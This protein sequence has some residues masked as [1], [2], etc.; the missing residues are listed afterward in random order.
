MKIQQLCKPVKLFI[1][2]IILSCCLGFVSFQAWKCLDKFFQYPQGSQLTLKRPSEILLPD[3]SICPGPRFGRRP[4]VEDIIEEIIYLNGTIGDLNV[5]LATTRFRLYPGF[6]AKKIYQAFGSVCFTFSL[7]P[8]ITQ[9]GI[10]RLEMYFI[11]HVFI[12]LHTPGLF[13]QETKYIEVKATTTKVSVTTETPF[14]SPWITKLEGVQ[15]EV[16]DVYEV[17]DEL[18]TKEKPCDTNTEYRRDQCILDEFHKVSKIR[19]SFSVYTYTMPHYFQETMEQFGCTPKFGANECTNKTLTRFTEGLYAD[20]IIDSP[21]NAKCLHPCKKIMPSFS[22]RSN[23]YLEGFSF[24][25]IDFPSEVKVIKAYPAYEVLSLIAEIG[26]Y[27]GLFLGISVMDLK[28]L[29]SFV[30]Q[31][32]K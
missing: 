32:R 8:N 4:E 18:D 5:D 13:F 21:T 25:G 17:I 19:N 30:L 20:M 28:K 15:L 27:V 12:K 10:V 7:P 3:I 29:T 6:E 1:E 2:I 23:D 26:G 22:I 14:E 11:D 24:L 31:Q 9:T 16:D